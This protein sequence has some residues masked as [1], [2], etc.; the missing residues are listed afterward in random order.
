ML[1]ASPHPPNLP[2]HSLSTT[3]GETRFSLLPPQEGGSSLLACPG[4]CPSLLPPTRHLLKLLSSSAENSR[5]TSS[6]PFLLASAFRI[7]QR[8][9]QLEGQ[10]QTEKSQVAQ[11]PILECWEEAPSSFHLGS[12]LHIEGPYH[13]DIATSTHRFKLCPDKNSFSAQI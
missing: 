13:M 11:L 4:S 1:T 7:L 3:P 10:V 8:D 6:A 2:F 9:L 12:V 5:H